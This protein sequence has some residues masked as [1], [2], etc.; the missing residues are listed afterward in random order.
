MLAR[1]AAFGGRAEGG[2]VQLCPGCGARVFDFCFGRA[3]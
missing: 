1:L 3:S 2:V